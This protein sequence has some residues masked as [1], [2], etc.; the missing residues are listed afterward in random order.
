[1]ITLRAASETSCTDVFICVVTK[2]GQI[3]CE[4]QPFIQIE[5]QEF[6]SKLK[7]NGKLKNLI[8]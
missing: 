6:Q 2:A 5:A 4:I 8:I 1:M 7:S 3:Y